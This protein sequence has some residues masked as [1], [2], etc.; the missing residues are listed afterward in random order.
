[1]C[2]GD[3]VGTNILNEML[4][5]NATDQFKSVENNSLGNNTVNV[6]NKSCS[7]T[8]KKKKTLTAENIV[9]LKSLGFVV[10]AEAQLSR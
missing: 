6:A 3:N 9:F 10:S 1:M 2:G 8:V 4:V 7:C 5:L